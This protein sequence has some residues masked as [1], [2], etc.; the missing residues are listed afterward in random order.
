MG[1]AL[2]IALSGCAT[3]IGTGFI[4]SAARDAH[5]SHVAKINSSKNAGKPHI[6]DC[7][8]ATVSYADYATWGKRAA[9]SCSTPHQLYTFAVPA[10]AEPH[11]SD[12]YLDKNENITDSVYNDGYNTCSGAEATD[13][14]DFAYDSRVYLEFYFPSTAEWKRGAR[15]MRCDF[16]IVAVGSSYAHPKFENLPA[17]SALHT[18]MQNAPYK[19]NLCTN[20]PGGVGPEG[21]NAVFADCSANPQWTLHGGGELPVRNHG[22]YPTA[23]EMTNAYDNSCKNVYTDATH[24]TYAYY[25]SKTDW[26]NGDYEFECWIG[27]K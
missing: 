22:A 23:A 5:E 19:F 1:V 20:D 13:L 26:Q 24:V 17:F 21:A 14:A 16:G 10:L 3:V 7:W 9:V 15:W 4:Q 25:P 12:S 2:A 8:V 18:T 11:K 6:G 27:R